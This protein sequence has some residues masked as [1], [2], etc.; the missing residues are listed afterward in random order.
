M[1]KTYGM[2]V[3][4]AAAASLAILFTACP[5]EDTPGPYEFTTPAS[6]RAMESLAGGS[7]TT[8][9]GSEVFI[10]DRPVPLGA[11]KI[12][13]YETTYQLWKEVYDWAVKNGYTFAN[14]GWEGHD[15]GGT[16]TVGTAAEKATRPVTTINWRD[17][18]VW[19]NAYS[20]LS[21]KTPVYYADAAYTTVLKESTNTE[22]ATAE[23]RAE[24]NPGANGYRL[25]T[26]V[27]WEYAA[28]G[29][30]Q[31]DT[32]NWDYTYAGRNFVDNVAWYEVNS[33]S[34]YP[35][36]S[37]ADRGAHR[38][39][40]KAANSK[41]LYDMSGNVYEWC[42]DWYGTIS[43][44]TPIGGAASGTRRVAR[45]GS[46]FDVES[47][48]TVAFRSNGNPYYEDSHVGFRVVCP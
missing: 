28:R 5:P 6:Y 18:I 23:D 27:E 34:F 14:P 45:G 1:K 9:T 10:T 21:G 44:S 41:G 36:V 22:T 19:C 37:E 24:M 35:G 32:T 12:A 29:G 30:N 40:T 2:G 42:W 26:E 33:T 11:F 38:V 7:I 8:T 20:E 3:F 46:W 47:S 25:P 16:G 13:K 31:S 17:A 4:L 39:G 48:C 43:T 15:R